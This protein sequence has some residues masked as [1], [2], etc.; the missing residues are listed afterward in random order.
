MLSDTQLFDLAGRMSVPLE[1]VAFKDDLPPLKFNRVYIVNLEDELDE[2][3]KPNT[4]SHWTAFYTVKHPNDTV[5]SM[6]FDPFGAAPPRDVKKF[7]EKLTG[8]SLPHTAKDIQSL[9]G[10]CC[11]FFCLAWAH[12]VT[13]SPYRSKDLIQDTE[14]FL[15][16]FDDLN[17]SVDFK[18][19]EYVLKHFFQ[20]ND[21]A[22]RIPISLKDTIVHKG[23]KDLKN[24]L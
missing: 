1:A 23:G 12:F 22:N 11:G 6:Y 17:S 8:E 24:I 21:P 2:H 4:G 10:E 3:G 16:M 9:M 5:D 20:S 7:V 15:S 19:N 18:K 13:A 14:S